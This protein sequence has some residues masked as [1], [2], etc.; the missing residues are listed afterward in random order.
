MWVLVLIGS[1]PTEYAPCS[2]PHIAICSATTTTEEHTFM[3]YDDQKPPRKASRKGKGKGVFRKY[4]GDKE[5]AKKR[6]GRD[7]ERWQ[8]AWQDSIRIP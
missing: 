8:D 3:Y 4:A 2:A 5:A 7:G 6:R 1:R